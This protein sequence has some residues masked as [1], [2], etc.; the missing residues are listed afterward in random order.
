MGLQDVVRWFVPKEDRFYD[1]LEGQAVVAHDGAKALRQFNEGKSAEEVREAVQEL[2]H[3]GDKIS[4][5][6]EQAIA[7]TFVTPLDRE[8]LQK[9]SGEL[10]DILD[11]TNGAMR[12]AVLYGV[13]T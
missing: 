1:Y 2:E 4:H 12:A 5:M 10:D 11:L 6:M 13:E 3:Q 7:T 9:L 8:D